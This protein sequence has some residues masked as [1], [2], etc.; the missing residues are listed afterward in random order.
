MEWTGL[1]I[2]VAVA[3][4]GWLVVRSVRSSPAA[5]SGSPFRSDDRSQ[6]AFR[7]RPTANGSWLEFYGTP[8]RLAVLVVAPAGRDGQL[9]RARKSCRGLMEQ[10]IPGLPQVI[11]HHRPLIHRW[12]AQLS[13]QGFVRAFFLP[14]GVP[15]R[16][17]TRDAVV[18]HRRKIP[19]RGTGL[20]G[21][22]GIVLGAIQQSR[23]T[24]GAA[25]G[26]MAG[27]PAFPRRAGMTRPR[28]PQ[29][30]RDDAVAIWRAGV[31]RR[32]GRAVGRAARRRAGRPVAGGR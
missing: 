16:P 9:P 6:S 30:L 8:V 2:A 19:G 10:L 13:S 22:V 11:A 23:S 26:T 14:R 31:R 32:G 15:G 17:G 7:C 3:I 12:P 1:A 21:R 18:R 25:R 29:E 20:S 28:T 24:H 4:G 27:H 5:T